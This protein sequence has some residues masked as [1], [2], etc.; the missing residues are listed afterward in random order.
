MRGKGG[1]FWPTLPVVPDAPPG[2]SV[3][4]SR[5]CEEVPSTVEFSH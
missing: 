4:D 2:D 5:M 3:R 1:T